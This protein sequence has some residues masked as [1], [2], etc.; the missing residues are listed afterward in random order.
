M[1][2]FYGSG[3][4]C[5]D[6]RRLAARV[7]R[8]GIRFLVAG[9][10]VWAH[11]AAAQD[12]GA[13]DPCRNGIVVPEPQ[14][15]AGLVADCEVLWGLRGQWDLSRLNW[16][17]DTPISQWQAVTVSDSGVTQLLLDQR[18]LG[19]AIPADLGQ[20]SELESLSLQ[21]NDLTGDIPPELGRLTILQYLDLSENGLT[22]EI[23]P[24]MGRLARLEYLDL[25]NNDLTGE[26]PVMGRLAGLE[27]L[28]LS[29]NDLT[30][31]IPPELGQLARLKELD[32]SHNRLSGPVPPELIE[33]LRQNPEIVVAFSDNEMICVP[34]S[35]FAIGDLPVCPPPPAASTSPAAAAGAIGGQDILD[36]PW[37]G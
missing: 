9:L 12:G 14:V 30:G 18:R 24:E 7:S 17:L 22:G 36:G 1:H 20:L 28:D 2:R 4:W 15:H 11:P 27:Y 5:D 6:R 16:N 35:T 3:G 13:A 25:S 34:D 37:L 19:G 10:V 32:L 23:P 21:S 8:I 29:D 31:G 26:I 33:L